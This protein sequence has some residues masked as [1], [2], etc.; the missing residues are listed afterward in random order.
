[1]RTDLNN[2]KP[3]IAELD[4]VLL[5]SHEA[6][7]TTYPANPELS[8]WLE[9]KA[10][11]LYQKGRD[12]ALPD[13]VRWLGFAPYGTYEQINLDELKQAIKEYEENT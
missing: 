7:G 8:T 2:M 13:F 1:M 10:E 6:Y 4:K 11:E 12:D 5:K 3:Y 9:A